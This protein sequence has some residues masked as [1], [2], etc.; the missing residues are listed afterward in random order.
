M[1][2]GPLLRGPFRM[3]WRRRKGVALRIARERGMR[4]GILAAAA[5]LAAIAACGIC[6]GMALAD[7][8]VDG[9]GA[10]RQAVVGAEADADGTAADP[11]EGSDGA[12]IV[13]D[14]V[15]DDAFGD[16]AD[17]AVSG[18]GAADGGDAV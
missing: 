13:S 16:V 5:L 9:D 3:Q 8:G 1:A 2:S 17:G 14:G 11:V 12:G 18:D 10:A 7:E 4:S 15:A 6:P